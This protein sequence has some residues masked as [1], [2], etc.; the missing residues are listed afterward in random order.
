MNKSINIDFPFRDS[1]EG[2]FLKLNTE[3]SKAIKADLLHL[4]LTNKGE[5]LYLPEFGTNLRTYLF[6]PYDGITQEEIKSEISEAVKKYLP[7]L[8][9]NSVIIEEAPQN[10]Y[11]AVVRLDYTITEDVFESKDFVIIQ[12]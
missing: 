7:N 2:F 10:Q 5:R 1:K 8:K 6:N 12:L 4:I 3:D 11:G 9:I